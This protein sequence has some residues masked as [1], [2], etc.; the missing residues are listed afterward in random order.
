MIGVE[1]NASRGGSHICI[2]GLTLQSA[3]TKANT[4]FFPWL[5]SHFPCYFVNIVAKLRVQSC[6]LLSERVMW[7]PCQI[8]WT[9]AHVRIDWYNFC[10]CNHFESR[11]RESADTLASF[12]KSIIMPRTSFLRV[13]MNCLQPRLSPHGDGARQAAMLHIKTLNQRLSSNL[14]AAW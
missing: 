3:M 2:T 5:S 14:C 9:P 10:S 4:S 1:K 12:E 6:E 11:A 8:S 13:R 7:R